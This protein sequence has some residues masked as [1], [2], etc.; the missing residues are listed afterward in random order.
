MRKKRYRGLLDNLE[1]G[2][3]VHGPGKI[4]MCNSSELIGIGSDEI[5]GKDADDSG[6]QFIHEDGSIMAVKDYPIV[7]ILESKKAINNYG[8]SSC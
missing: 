5:L 7:K 4:L 8:N 2:I 6:W 1:A 3:V